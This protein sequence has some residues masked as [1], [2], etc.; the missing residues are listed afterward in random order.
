MFLFR[1]SVHL[2]VNCGFGRNSSNLHCQRQQMRC[3]PSSRLC[4]SEQRPL[5]LP[6]E[7][8]SWTRTSDYGHKTCPLLDCTELLSGLR[9]PQFVCCPSFFAVCCV[10]NPVP[11]KCVAA[12]VVDYL[13]DKDA[14]YLKIRQKEVTK[15]PKTPL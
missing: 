1:M 4:L 9:H 7:E 6:H 15:T 10:L 13:P 2:V 3:T 12:Q 5:L 11:V 14:V 8:L